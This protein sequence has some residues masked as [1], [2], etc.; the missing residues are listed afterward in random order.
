MDDNLHS[1]Q[2]R[3]IE[4]RIEHADLDSLIDGIVHRVPID[5]LMLRRLKKRRLALRD[6][7][8]RLERMLDPPE[9]A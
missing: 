7:I 2:R 5:E 8:A 9:P 4:L 1:P 3:L 6:M